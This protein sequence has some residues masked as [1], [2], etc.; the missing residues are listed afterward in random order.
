MLVQPEFGADF[1]WARSGSVVVASVDGLAGLCALLASHRAL[2]S[3]RAGHEG[4]A[5][6]REASLPPAIA[7]PEQREARARELAMLGLAL[8]VWL[9]LPALVAHACGFV[10]G[11]F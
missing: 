8:T 10:V 4:G 7:S 2:R 6:Y 9:A 3:S 11:L 5:S 1:L